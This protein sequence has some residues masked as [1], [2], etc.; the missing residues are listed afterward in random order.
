M[1]VEVEIRA[2]AEALLSS[3]TSNQQPSSQLQQNFNSQATRYATEDVVTG[4][5][6]SGHMSVV[7]R[8]F[9]LFVTFDLLFI[10]LMWLIIILLNGD[11]IVSALSKQIVHYNI[12]T[13][14]FD[15]VMA[16]T[17]RFTF[18]LLF[19]GLLYICHWWVIALST[20][21]T[22]AFLI[23]KV[24][25]Y[26]WTLANQPVFHVLLVL[27]S[28]VLSWGEAWFLDF[29]VLPQE[30]QAIEYLQGVSSYQSERAPLLGNY[31]QGLQR[32]DDYTESIGNFYSPMDS[33]QSSDEEG[34]T[35]RSGAR[36][37]A[38]SQ[39]MKYRREGQEVLEVSW[40]ILNS[41]DWKLEK[42]TPEGDAVYSKKMPLAGKVL[43]LTGAID[44]PPKRLLNELFDKVENHPEWNPTILETRT[45]QVIDD[46]TDINYQVARE[47]G[48]GIVSSRDFVNLRH[49][50]MKDGC[51]VSAGVS[52]KHPSVP[53][54]KQYVRGEN[55]PTCW[56][57]RP[58]A[59]DENRCVFQW[60]LNINLK[61]WLPHSI[62][63]AALTASM[64]DYVRCVREYTAKLKQESQ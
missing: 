34:D 31:L 57:M 3:S 39:D 64:L 54:V 2:A 62:V 17:C 20:A 41:P 55:G 43:K 4:M 58:V 14:L 7:R 21:G 33:P 61:G 15:I 46:H 27:I 49:W 19:Y 37:R 63:D 13:S 53:P 22:C 25:V 10:T 60:L 44:F 29:R 30:L 16:A 8:F 45:V 26:N 11:D 38:L 12:H 36:G 24:F 32:I 50:G 40:R 18:L 56:V 35:R 28:F 47:V 42:E 5:Q 51:Y 48:G 23:G 1:N 9:C 52:V 59:G 6:R